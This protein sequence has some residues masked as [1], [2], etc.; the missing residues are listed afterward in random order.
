MRA[1]PLLL[2]L[3]TLLAGCRHAF[4]LDAAVTSKAAHCAEE[5]GAGC[6]GPGEGAEGVKGSLR[7]L[8]VSKAEV[9]HVHLRPSQLEDWSADPVD[10][11]LNIGPNAGMDY[12]LHAGEWDVMLSDCAGKQVLARR[13]VRVSDAGAIVTFK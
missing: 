6:V 8:N 11:D 7:I 5:A 9:C 1:P 4:P 13:K 12:P 2:S 10:E 3:V